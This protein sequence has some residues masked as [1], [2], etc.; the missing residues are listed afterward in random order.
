MGLCSL[1]PHEPVE[2]AASTACR[3]PLAGAADV[4]RSRRAR[5]PRW[6]AMR[7]AISPTGTPS[8]P[9]PWRTD[10]SAPAP[11]RGG[12]A[13]RRPGGAPQASVANR[14]QGSR[15]RL[16]VS[17]MS[18]STPRGRAGPRRGPPE[19]AAPPRRARRARPGDR[20]TV[21][22][23]A[24]APAGRPCRR[25]GFDGHSDGSWRLRGGRGEA[26][27][28]TAGLAGSA[29]SCASA[30]SRSAAIRADPWPVLDRSVTRQSRAA[31]NPGADQEPG[32][33]SARAGRP[34][35]GWGHSGDVSP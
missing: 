19:P 24:R 31:R 34:P 26:S 35:P 11:R 14:R 20:A 9:T 8:S 32:S 22:R 1:C 2:V 7:S 6:L 10:R 5:T 27:E 13:G 3:I 30:V 18:A 29:T 28:L 4:A 23:A 12:R 17:A 33:A 16:S 15:R 25:V 21:S